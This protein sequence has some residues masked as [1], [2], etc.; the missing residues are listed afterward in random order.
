MMIFLSLTGTQ[1]MPGTREL[2]RRCSTRCGRFCSVLLLS[3]HALLCTACASSDGSFV[4]RQALT[5][6]QK[7]IALQPSDTIAFVAPAGELDGER[8]ALAR[9]RLE[10]RGY[11]VVQADDLLRHWGYLGGTD[12]RRAEELMAAF[13]DPEID[14]IFPG[15][16]GYG[17]TRM[18]RLLDF[19]VIAE[20]PKVLIG[21]SDITALHIAIHQET[22]LISFHTPNPMYGLGTDSGMFPEAEATFWRA[23]EGAPSGESEASETRVGVG[24]L[25]DNLDTH[26]LRAVAT[27]ESGSARGR[28][29]G[30]NL[31]LIAALM[32]TPWE[33]DT[34]GKILFMEDVRESPYRIDRF[35]AQL[36]D[37][38]KFDDCAG[39]IIGQFSRC[40]PDEDEAP[41]AVFTMDQLLEQYFA[42]LDKPVI[43]NFPLGHVRENFTLPVGAMAEIDTE[44]L[45]VRVLEEPV[46]IATE[47]VR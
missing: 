9:Q 39:I 6:V 24:Y 3:I 25:I 23:L 33:I 35:F 2:S 43:A 42:D 7:A 44:A 37:A 40:D 5:G 27:N 26:P 11:K 18:L 30:G 20:N 34:R 32:G 17:T 10:A 14:A 45:T 12:E 38:G 41:D 8:M 16:G 19:D 46:R 4:A 36:R 29:I 47:A 21:F 13:A 28:L 15:T 31:S 1:T 22:G